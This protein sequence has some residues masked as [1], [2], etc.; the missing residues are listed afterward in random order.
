MT[1]NNLCIV[2]ISLIC[3]FVILCV[4]APIQ[5]ILRAGEKLYFS[6][7]MLS[8]GGFFPDSAIRFFDRESS[9]DP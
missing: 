7:S 6:F 5:T 9:N 1:G 2:S 8:K 4:N 3:I